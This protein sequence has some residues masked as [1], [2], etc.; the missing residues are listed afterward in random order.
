MQQKKKRERWALYG[1]IGVER[2]KMSK[3]TTTITI[4]KITHKDLV[5]W[6]NKNLR[7]PKDASFDDVIV[8]LLE[9]V[10]KL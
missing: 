6:A 1:K 7:S 8:N 9:I 5:D 3:D 4:K 2:F 10:N